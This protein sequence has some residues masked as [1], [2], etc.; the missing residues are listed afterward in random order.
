MDAAAVVANKI[1]AE[2]ITFDDVLLIPR[3]S[4]FVPGD[5]DVSTRLTRR[6][7][8]NVPLVSAPMDT[9]TESSLAIA[10][11][12]E[13][14]LG[15]IHKNLSPEDQAREVEKVKRSENGVILDPVTLPPNATLAEARRIMRDFNVSGIPIVDAPPRLPDDAGESQPAAA[16][17]DPDA[18]RPQVAGRRRPPGQRRDDEQRTL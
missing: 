4:D 15:F 17:G 6:V 7:T 9:V 18:S 2:A 3:R 13:G 16:C 8:L 11:A 10:L 14:G 1:I 5:A 12:Q